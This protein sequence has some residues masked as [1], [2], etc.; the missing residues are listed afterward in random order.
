M[1]VSTL[2]PEFGP[3]PYLH[4]HPETG[5]P[6]ADL[7]QICDWMALRQRARFETVFARPRAS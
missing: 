3:P 1:S 5:E 4:T 2:T 6:L 7:N